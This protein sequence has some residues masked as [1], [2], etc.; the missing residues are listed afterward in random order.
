MIIF[1]GQ[2]FIDH[3]KT[4]DNSIQRFKGSEDNTGDNRILN[5]ISDKVCGD[6]VN[7]FCSKRDEVYKN[8]SI[9]RFFKILITNKRDIKS[10]K[11]LL[12]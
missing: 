9:F 3:E 11:E 12:W 10:N 8:K 5:H 7:D 1:A 2:M 4:L 6:N